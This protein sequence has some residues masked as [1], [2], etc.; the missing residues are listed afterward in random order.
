MC[1][2]ATSSITSY[3]YV[4]L[5]TTILCLYGNKYDQHISLY[6]FVVIQMQLAEFLMHIDPKCGILNKIGTL[7]AFLIL[8]I[9]PVSAYT[10]G[11][12]LETTDTPDYFKYIY[13]IWGIMGV[14]LFVMYIMRNKNICS[15]KKNGF[16][17][18][19][20]ESKNRMTDFFWGTLYLLLTTLPFLYLQ[21]ET[22]KYLF[23][24]I[25]IGSCTLHYTL[26]PNNWKSIW[27]FFLSG[28][29]TIYALVRYLQINSENFSNIQ[30]VDSV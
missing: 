6:F 9:Q 24:I 18:W 11:D 23:L 16:L 15:V 27:C 1:Y 7:S 3:I 20:F 5:I 19:G 21:E 26:Y 8:F 29:I 28:N 10:L 25:W 12:Q 22:I 13:T 2:N 30:M 4:A 17:M 14:I